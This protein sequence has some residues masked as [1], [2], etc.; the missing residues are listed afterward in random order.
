MLDI[1]EL[2]RTMFAELMKAA[3]VTTCLRGP[4][5]AESWA[6]QFRGRSLISGTRGVG[7]SLTAHRPSPS[8]P[9]PPNS[10]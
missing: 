10:V 1:M 7:P 2:A 5:P 9:R 4:R 3:N 6:L 8:V